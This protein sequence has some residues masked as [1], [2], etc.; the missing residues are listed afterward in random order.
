MKREQVKIRS[1]GIGVGGVPNP[2]TAFLIRWKFVQTWRGN[3]YIKMEL[4]LC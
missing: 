3:G 4:E 1:Y 2:M